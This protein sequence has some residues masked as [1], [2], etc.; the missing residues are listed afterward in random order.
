MASLSFS[1]LPISTSTSTTKKPLFSTNSSHEK[2]SHRYKFSCT[3]TAD[4]NDKTVEN[5]DTPKLILP[6][7]PSLDM[8]NVDRRN[9]LL[10]LGGLYSAANLTT[11]PLAF[12]IPIQAPNDISSCVAARSSIPNQKEALR[13]IACCPPKRST[14]PPGRYNF[15]TDQA[16]RV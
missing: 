16:I 9:L 2:R 11:I 10:G 4:D 6:K 3:A 1:T 7:S 12:G 5:S 14:R 8:Q 15:R 13:G